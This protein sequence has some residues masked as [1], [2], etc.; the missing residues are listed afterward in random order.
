[1]FEPRPTASHSR[2]SCLVLLF[3]VSFAAAA[4]A[5]EQ[6]SSNEWR[7]MGAAPRTG[8]QAS[9]S[10]ATPAAWSTS[11]QPS[12][13][14]EPASGETS[15][16]PVKAG[17]SQPT[18][19]EPRAFRAPNNAKPLQFSAQAAG[20]NAKQQSQPPEPAGFTGSA[21]SPV[22]SRSFVIPN[23]TAEN[24]PAAA[25]RSVKQRMVHPAAS[26]PMG[27]DE[28]YNNQ[29]NTINVAFQGPET[30]KVKQSPEAS[31]VIKSERIP[32]PANADTQDT[33]LPAPVMRRLGP[34]GT[35]FGG[36][37]GEG[38]D[39]FADPSTCC[40]QGECCDGYGGNGYGCNG[41][42][43]DGN[44][45]DRICEPGC[46]CGCGSPCEPGCGCEPSC[47]CD[48]TRCD[49]H[50]FCIGPGDDESCH[51]VKLRWP[52][53]QEVLVFGGV[54]G[55]KSPYDQDHD[56]GNFGFNEGFNIGAK[57]PYALAG[58]QFGWRGA[59]SQVNG[60]EA[61]DIENQN[62]EEFVTAGFFHR[63]CQ[64]LQIGTVWDM[65]NEERFH[66]RH[67]HQL[68]NELS[69]LNNCHEFGATAI[70]GLNDQKLKDDNGDDIFFE[71]TDQ[72]LLFYRI[73]GAKG[74]EGRIY[75]GFDNDSDTIVGADML[76][77]LGDRFSIQGG[78]T[79]LNP[80]AK[81]GED[82]A[83]QEAWNISLG[84]VWHWD[85]QAR[86]S[87][88]NCYRP[89]FNVADNGYLILTERDK[90]N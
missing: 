61:T 58:Y 27:G 18:N 54:Q 74:G 9:S 56:A 34:P 5:Q 64:G 51:V 55:F 88:E 70:I 20:S 8:S 7:A 59:Q 42:C 81:S 44:C 41:N 86:K 26:E 90:H 1:M 60:D 40:N 28:N 45:C 63:S 66:A 23:Q 65:L 89:M 31:K 52:K 46:A 38:F 53:W 75:A 29:S 33:E 25:Q 14:V 84:L 85:G 49:D 67:F 24:R 43:C 48:N 16:T 12:T 11:A 4:A 15:S 13:N 73:H 3:A 68:R 17:Q 47:G 30:S 87:H 80:D 36:L 78:F 22:A 21:N 39:P 72:F 77:P 62:F 50:E 19:R 76:I 2:S 57:V 6:S 79:F 82:G 35:N 83:S 69:F 37:P 10:S 32:T 71:A